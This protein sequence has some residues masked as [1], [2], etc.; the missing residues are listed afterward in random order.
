MAIDPKDYTP[1]SRLLARTSEF[2]RLT[3]KYI[4]VAF[5][6][7]LLF[8]LIGLVA[9]IKT[10]FF[11]QKMIRLTPAPTLEPFEKLAQ[12][13]PFKVQNPPT[14]L[15][16]PDRLRTKRPPDDPNADI[17]DKN[18]I[19]RDRQPKNLS[20]STPFS[21]GDLAMK[22]MARDEENQQHDPLADG[23]RPPVP[24]QGGMDNF[25]DAK[26]IPQWTKELL[27]RPDYRG[28]GGKTGKGAGQDQGLAS[29]KPSR[30]GP[31]VKVLI[32]PDDLNAFAQDEDPRYTKH[33]KFG[34]SIGNRGPRQPQFL[35]QKSMAKDFGDF[36]FSTT[37][38]DF[39]PYLYYLR[40]RVRSY[41]HV[42]EAFKLG[43]V[44]GRVIV[45]FKIHRNGKLTDLEVLSYRDNDIAYQSLVNA[46]RNAILSASPFR[47]LPEDFPDDF[48]E[49]RGSFYYQILGREDN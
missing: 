26:D 27:L 18:A 46:S 45:Q 32:P 23:V 13:Q 17:A 22:S 29:E 3:S 28:K 40:E 4:L 7:A 15:D 16:I 12:H 1:E 5:A 39:A 34:V 33:K 35:S 41:W 21:L 24:R 20:E 48:L 25:K 8:H 43:M 42:P 49:I 30:L 19:A 10:D 47:S 36:S 38:W 6:I 31:K 2:R 14:L 11:G 44:S 9:L 37:A